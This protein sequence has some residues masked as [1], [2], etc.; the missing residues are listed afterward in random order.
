M[1]SASVWVLH[2]EFSHASHDHP[3]HR[4]ADE[5]REYRA[6]WASLGDGVAG[7]DE[8]AGANDTAECDHDQ[9]AHFEC[10]A[11]ASIG[12]DGRLLGCVRGM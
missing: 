11:Y 2:R 3:G 1:E 9:V 7:A 12:N 5:V 6:E 10:T 8:Q 4:C